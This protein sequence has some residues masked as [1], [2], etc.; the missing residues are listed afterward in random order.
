M[1]TET[2]NVEPMLEEKY[3]SIVTKESTYILQKS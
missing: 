3:I 2:R 1:D